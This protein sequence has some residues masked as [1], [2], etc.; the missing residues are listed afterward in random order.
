MEPRRTRKRST[1]QDVA[2]L[3][4]VSVTTVSFVINEKSGGNIRIS[5]ETRQRVWEAV[6]TL[7]Y[8]PSSAARALRTK[9]SGLL[10]LVLPHLKTSY[11]PLLA[12][13]V[14]N[15]A[16][17]E[18]FDIIIHTTQ[19]EIR[20]EQDLLK[21]V[22][23]RDVDG[24]IVHSVQQTSD[25][26]E[27][28]VEAGISVVIHG[29]LPVHPFVDNVM[30]DELKAVEEIVYYLMDKG[31]VRIGIIS[32][33]AATWIGRMRKEGYLSA[34]RAR[35]IPIEDELIYDA[36]SWTLGAGTLGMQSLLALP[37]PPTAV[38]AASDPLAAEA[39]LVALDT[40]LSVP[41]DVAIAGIDDTPEATMV[42]PKLTTV[43]KDVNQLGATATQLLMERIECEEL[44]PARQITL[45][46]R[47][48]PRESA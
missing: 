15:A 10:A 45:S 5:E 14:Q 41:E 23:S 48:V 40:G 2:D 22:R 46:H 27:P 35:G 6:K 7:D 43:H 31:H 1:S 29:N 30:I 36:A 16:K 26:I 3:A 42:R 38:F 39:L 12:T 28:L 11:H 8:R 24:V 19:N 9:R 20:L 17:Q 32:G 44:L 13:S 34:L 37:E 4:G 33:P 25:D 21:T 47:I 18:G